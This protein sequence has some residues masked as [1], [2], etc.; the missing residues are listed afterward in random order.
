MN[1]SCCKSQY[2][3]GISL[4]DSYMASTHYHEDFFQYWSMRRYSPQPH[5]CEGQWASDDGEKNQ[6]ASHIIG[7]HVNFSGCGC[8]NCCLAWSILCL[9]DI[10]APRWFVR[11][12]IESVKGYAVWFAQYCS[13]L[14]VDIG[15]K[16]KRDNNRRWYKS[17]IGKALITKWERMKKKSFLDIRGYCFHSNMLHFKQNYINIFIQLDPTKK[18]SIFVKSISCVH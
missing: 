16:N 1:E 9:Q 15:C 17:V 12:D 3:Q 18:M 10:L 4:W 13:W 14:L 8:K 11:S 5:A 2:S 6:G 7:S